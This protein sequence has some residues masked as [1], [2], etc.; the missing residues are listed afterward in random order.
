MGQAQRELQRLTSGGILRRR[1]Q[2]RHIY[3]QADEHCPIYNELRGIVTK[4]VGA[5]DSVGDALRD[6]EERIRI[7]F[8]FGSVARGEERAGS[9]IDL[10]IVGDVSL[11]EVVSVLGDAQVKLGREISPM[12]YPEKE[13][14]S[15]VS[16]GHPFLTSVLEREK[17]FVIGSQDELG[18]LLP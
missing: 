14:R 2:G 4:T 12:I 18:K 7:A 5:A 17:I 9:D 11:R 15:K 1:E 8:L 13:L 6:L 16:E 10:V 3:F